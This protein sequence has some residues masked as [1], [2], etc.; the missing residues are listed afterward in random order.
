MMLF[1]SSSKKLHEL[2]LPVNYVAL[3]SNTPAVYCHPDCATLEVLARLL[4]AKFLLPEIR[5]YSTP[6]QNGVEAS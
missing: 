2:P 4:S 3:A 5:Y 6:M 1:A